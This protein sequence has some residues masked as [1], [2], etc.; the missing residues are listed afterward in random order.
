MVNERKEGWTKEEAILILEEVKM[1]D[2]SM[3]QYNQGYM[4]ALNMAIEALQTATIHMYGQKELIVCK[5]CKHMINCYRAVL[6]YGKDGS[7]EPRHLDS[8][9]NRFGM[10]FCSLAE[11]K[12]MMR[13]EYIIDDDFLDDETKMSAESQGYLRELI[14][15]KDCKYWLPHSQFGSG[16]DNEAYYDYC[17]KLVP[18]DDYYAF[19]RNADD[20]CSR[21][22]RKENEESILGNYAAFDNGGL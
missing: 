3:Y 12:D 21:A 22:K 2:D 13:T 1:F 14:R 7:V 10:G 20:F 15:C 18:E 6:M 17:E 8:F 16:E 4:D 19:I 5:D 9:E 11:R